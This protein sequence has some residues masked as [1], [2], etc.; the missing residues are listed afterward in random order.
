[1]ARPDDGR[2]WRHVFGRSR[3]RRLVV[4]T[5][6]GLVGLASIGFL[7]GVNTGLSL[8]WVVV[9]LGVAFVAGWLGAGLVPT[10]GSLWLVGLWWFV[11]PP[12]VGYLSGDWTSAS[13]YTHPRMLGFAYRTARAELVG[14]FEYGLQFGLLFAV[15]GGGVGYVAGS[16]IRYLRRRFRALQ[17]G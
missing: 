7:L 13:R 8:W 9:A 11:F 12:L 5:S 17:P 1:M 16:G 10:V 6:V 3:P 15:V 14:G 2:W 4:T